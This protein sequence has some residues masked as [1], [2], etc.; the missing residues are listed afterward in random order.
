MII[1]TPYTVI[2]STKCRRCAK[3]I[4]MINTFSVSVFNGEILEKYLISLYNIG[5]SLLNADVCCTLAHH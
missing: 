5:G 2:C 1:N 3:F 4:K